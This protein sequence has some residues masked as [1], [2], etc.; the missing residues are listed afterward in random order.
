MGTY[1]RPWVRIGCIRR[2]QPIPAYTVHVNHVNRTNNSYFLI[3]DFD[4]VNL[5]TSKEISM[6]MWH[7][8]SF[9]RISIQS[10][11]V[12][13]S[14]RCSQDSVIHSTI[15]KLVFR[16]AKRSGLNICYFCRKMNFSRTPVSTL[17]LI[18]RRPPPRKQLCTR[19][20]SNKQ[21]HRYCVPNNFW[22]WQLINYWDDCHLEFQGQA[23]PLK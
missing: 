8:I 1:Y 18:S 22:Q 19:S 3:P 20:G 9:F 4:S 15:V 11:Y 7:G 17:R 2:I 14:S 12:P 5:C 10:T 21:T 6:E 16:R 23:L 13:V